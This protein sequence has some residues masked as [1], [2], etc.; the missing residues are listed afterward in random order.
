MKENEKSSCEICEDS[1]IFDLHDLS[2]V[3]LSNSSHEWVEF[4]PKQLTVI[5]MK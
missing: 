5:E 3:F 1:Y 2:D 4:T